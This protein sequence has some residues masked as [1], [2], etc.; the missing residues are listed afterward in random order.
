MSNPTVLDLFCGAGGFSEG[1]RQQ[2]FTIELGID[3]WAPAL[4][5]YSHNFG[6]EAQSLDLATLYRSQKKIDLLPDTDVI[7][8]SPPCV[9]FSHA[10]ISGKADKEAGIQLTKLFLKIVAVKKFKPNSRLKAWCMENVANS[11]HYLKPRYRFKD[12]GLGKW[13]EKNGYQPDQVAINLE[14]GQM[15][16]NSAHYG[17]PQR[18]V[19]LFSGEIIRQ[20][21]NCRSFA[22]PKK[23]NGD[24]IAN[25]PSAMPT[26]RT[27]GEIKDALPDPNTSDKDS[28]VIDIQYPYIKIRAEDL[29]DHFYDTG[30]YECEWAECKY[31]KTNHPYMGRM[32]F[33]EDESKPCR[34][35]TATRIGVSRELMIFRSEY[36]RT[37]DGEFRAPTIREIACL[38]G[39]P[40]TFQFSGSES[41]KWKL[42]GNAV[43]PHVS[44]ALAKQL[45]AELGLEE[46]KPKRK[47]ESSVPVAIDNLNDYSE[48]VFSEPPRKNP[49]ARFRKHIWKD[50]NMTVTLSNYDIKKN[51][52]FLS[53]WIT[54]I[55]YGTHIGF[56][57]QGFRGDIFR[58][59]EPVI[60][61]LEYGE[62][63]LEE[64][65]NGFLDRVGTATQ[66][67]ELYERKYADDKLLAPDQLLKEAS[68]IIDRHTATS[69]AGLPAEA[70][71]FFKKKNVPVKQ[72]LALY[73]ISL[74]TARANSYE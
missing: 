33:P 36:T 19:R 73:A 61:Q 11:R 10:N 28:I 49:N 15:I 66:L 40:I 55:Q 43:S 4:S 20:G 6:V 5:T 44:H 8:G 2:G 45:R 64:M 41:T 53:K 22:E 69:P 65:N 24:P 47:A 9:S 31:L 32:S 58:R 16:L 14:N 46:L 17:S 3:K 42:I 59:L 72:L 51:T 23:T 62:S 37:G 1:F 13:A 39:F 21:S 60:Q 68:R 7:V 34:T 12:L 48:K 27:L 74:I 67:Q 52:K 71:R 25:E 57:V 26:F 30:L 18:R 29:S 50:G 35:I 56:P 70:S 38:M 63:F 54:S